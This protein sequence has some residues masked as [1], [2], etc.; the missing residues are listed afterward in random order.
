MG[1]AARGFVVVLLIAAVGIRAFIVSSRQEVEI[2]APP[3]TPTV[4]PKE[5]TRKVKVYQLVVKDN[6]PVLVP[7]VKEVKPGENSMQVAVKQ[8]LGQGNSS[9]MVNPI[10]RGTKLLGMTV[11]DGIATVDLSREFRDNFSGGSEDE[12]LAIGVFLRTL[13]QFPEVNKVAF[14]VEG[15]TLDT[16]GHLDLSVPQDVNSMEY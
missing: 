10:P 16:L 12:A 4:T 14:L 8:M 3:P 11:T 9:G 5:Q 6:Q 7:T 13:G 2:V 15:K 1:T